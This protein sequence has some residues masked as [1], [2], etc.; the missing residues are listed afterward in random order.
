MSALDSQVKVEGLI[1][2][3]G[4]LR[5]VHRDRTTT[6]PNNVLYRKS[7]DDSTVTEAQ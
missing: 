5:Q 4:A 7:A 1:I 3:P 2:D 6:L